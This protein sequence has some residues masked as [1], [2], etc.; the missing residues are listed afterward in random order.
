[1]ISLLFTWSWLIVLVAAIFGLC[2]WEA[3]AGH[4]IFIAACQVLRTTDGGIIAH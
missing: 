3:W 4:S 1:M 2:G